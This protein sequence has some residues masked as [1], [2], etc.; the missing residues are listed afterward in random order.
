MFGIFGSRTFH[1]PELGELRRSWGRWIAALVLDR[2]GPVRVR[3]RGTR[4]APDEAALALARQLPGRY[5]GLVPELQEL[6]HQ[7]FGGYPEPGEPGGPDEA[8]RPPITGA[9]DVWPHVEIEE[10]LIEPIGGELTVEIAY[11]SAWDQEHALGARIRGW[12]CVEL[13][14]SV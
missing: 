3:V 1:D 8:F 5:E 10:V 11:R 6:L 14:G 13:C 2:H 4:S 7:H 9:G 12:R